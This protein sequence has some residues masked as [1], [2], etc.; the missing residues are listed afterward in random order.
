MIVN[1]MQKLIALILSAL[2]SAGI[3]APVPFPSDGV[4]A[5]AN[6]IF[7][8]EEAGSAEGTAMLRQTLTQPMSFTGA[9]HRATSLP[10]AP[11]AAKLF[12]TA[13]SLRLT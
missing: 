12:L 9:T 11:Q 10:Q 2:I 3:I 13:G 8:R 5:N 6:F 1:F 4:K 7:T